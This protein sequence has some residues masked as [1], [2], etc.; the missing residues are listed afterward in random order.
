MVATLADDIFKCICFDE[1]GSI[2]IQ[3]S[4]NFVPKDPMNNKSSM[5]QVMAWAQKGYTP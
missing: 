5:V 4:L 3:N 1:N 2:S